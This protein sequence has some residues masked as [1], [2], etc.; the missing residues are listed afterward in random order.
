MVRRSDPTEAPAELWFNDA[1]AAAA[2]AA[3]VTSARPWRAYLRPRAVMR[4]GSSC[5]TL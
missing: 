5:E 3:I 2:A 4:E 1:G